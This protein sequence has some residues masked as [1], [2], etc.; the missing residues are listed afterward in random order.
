MN[1][2]DLV[3]SCHTQKALDDIRTDVIAVINSCE[4]VEEMKR[5]QDAFRKQKNRIRRGRYRQ[6][7][8]SE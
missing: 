7:E 2:Y 3:E 4:S 8:R 5:I 6:T 1:I